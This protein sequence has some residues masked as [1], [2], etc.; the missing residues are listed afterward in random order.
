MYVYIY[1]YN[2]YVHDMIAKWRNFKL[3]LVVETSV[4][5]KK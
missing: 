4:S 3:K 5:V 2:V 1:I